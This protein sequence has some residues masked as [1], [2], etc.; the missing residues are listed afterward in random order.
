MACTCFSYLKRTNYPLLKKRGKR[1]KSSKS[2]VPSQTLHFIISVFVIVTFLSSL[3]PVFGGDEF[4]GVGSLSVQ[5]SRYESESA[6]FE[7]SSL[8][9]S[10]F[11]STVGTPTYTRRT[12][13]HPCNRVRFKHNTSLR[14]QQR[15]EV[16]V[17]PPPGYS[18][19][20]KM[21]ENRRRPK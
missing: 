2:I 6:F 13:I 4:T 20:I 15:L 3:F 7:L 18:E 1:W 9:L 8:N 19:E 5:V 16:V 21:H 17:L 14:G 11:R 10:I 12:Y